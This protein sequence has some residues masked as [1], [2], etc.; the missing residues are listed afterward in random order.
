MQFQSSNSGNYQNHHQQAI[1][2]SPLR[3]H[4]SYGSNSSS[5]GVGG[6]MHHH[7]H[8]PS[9]LQSPY[10]ARSTPSPSTIAS[11][12]SP[13]F[14]VRDLDQGLDEATGAG[15]SNR[16]NHYNQHHHAS[17][18]SAS[19]L[20]R[21][22][23]HGT[24]AGRESPSKASASSSSRMQNLSNQSYY[25]GGSSSSMNGSSSNDSSSSSS[26]TMTPHSSA[27]GSALT[28]TSAS[29]SSAPTA[30]TST[31]SSTATA[32]PTSTAATQARSRNP[33]IDLIETEKGYVDDLGLVIKK[34]AAAWSRSN[35]P[36]PALDKMFRA[37]ESVYRID[38]QFLAK[39][40]E[41]GPNPSSPKALGD[42]L[43]RWIDDLEPAYTKYVNAYQGDFDNY[44]PV[45]SNPNLQ[46]ILESL[47]T[48]STP[49]LFRP[50]DDDNQYDQ[51]QQQ[52]QQPSHPTLDALFTLPLE[53]L[54]YFKKLYG[55]L[56][57]ST[58]PGKSDHN[59]L[60]GANEKL[61][62]LVEMSRQ[63]GERRVTDGLSDE[64]RSM[65]GT[66]VTSA[67]SEQASGTIKGRNSDEQQRQQQQ[68][69][70]RQAPPPESQSQSQTPA[71]SPAK[72]AIQQQLP[73]SSASKPQLPHV[74]SA[75]SSLSSKGSIIPPLRTTDLSRPPSDGNAS[76][77]SASSVERSSGQTTASS[78]STALTDNSQMSGG[79][80]STA[81]I[82]ADLE[83]RLDTSRT[84][85]IFT[86]KPKKCKLQMNPPNLP[87]QR[88]IRLVG[89]VQVS[90]VPASSP[91]Q[92]EVFTPSAV[93]Y[94]LTDLFLLCER[95]PSPSTEPNRT[96]PQADFW[97][98]YPPLA[99]KHL[100]AHR[101]Q[102][103]NAADTAFEVVIMRKERMTVYAESREK[104]DEWLEAFQEAINFGG[105]AGALRVN[106]D[107]NR[108]ISPFTAASMSA[109]GRSTP[110]SQNGPSPNGGDYSSLPPL[111]LSASTSNFPSNSPSPYSSRAPT[112]QETQALT[113]Q[114]R[115][116]PPLQT[117]GLQPQRIQSPENMSAPPPRTHG[118]QP[119]YQGGSLPSGQG[120][121]P[122]P[123]RSQ[124]SLPFP[125]PQQQ[126][127]HGPMSSQSPPMRA[128]P[129]PMQQS[130]SQPSLS[131]PMQGMQEGPSPGGY[132]NHPQHDSYPL[133]NQ[134][135][136]QYNENL[137]PGQAPFG[138][139]P[140]PPH[141][142]GLHKAP[143]MRSVGSLSSRSSGPG[144][145]HTPSPIPPLP[146]K[147]QYPQHDWQAAQAAN[148]RMQYGMQQGMGEYGMQPDM[149]QGGLLSP[150][151]S[152]AGMNSSMSSNGMIHR[153]KSAE[154]LRADQY[155]MPSAVL[156]DSLR[157]QSMPT[158]SGVRSLPNSRMNSGY[159]NDTELDISPPTSPQ[160]EGPVTNQLAAQMKCKVF[161]QSAKNQW[162]SLGTA[163]L[164]LYLQSPGNRKQLV[165]EDKTVLISTIVLEDGVERVGKT[166]VAIELSDNGQRTGLIYMLQLKT[167]ASATG[168][169][170]QLLLG[171]TRASAMVLK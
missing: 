148:Q 99:T 2:A 141:S 126:I 52:Q 171:S 51:Q 97:L 151:R 20:N 105:G 33:L 7:H 122:P 44:P 130:F 31:S 139:Q 13:S 38:K 127:G 21:F 104:R 27:P 82:L 111:P 78:A 23:A 124:A 118:Q 8:Q 101:S 143:S 147:E 28:P 62:W 19:S 80:Q 131:R 144:S 150:S 137:P 34:V 43:M 119:M 152:Q 115:A 83:K 123:P 146:M 25:A 77:V 68:S 140:P 70:Q 125:P 129:S 39:L 26:H 18:S 167:E 161:V 11:G 15:I 40:N 89:D 91:S 65:N 156:K 37:V 159:V 3:M 22:N 56:L 55:K 133:P 162:K 169:F 106:T 54:Q 41:I 58:Q 93:I 73:P 86:M 103:P 120:P 90:F 94:L 12:G 145:S 108:S 132:R 72:A 112:P 165:V 166:G 35:F 57:K 24:A 160:L 1:A 74:S 98:M 75:H 53:R 100:R 45:Q 42:L 164:K 71:P 154:G 69:Q 9:H 63:S 29:M 50:H 47:P 153:S 158:Q 157:G 61:D 5:G 16:S 168:L 170:Q 79:A 138:M 6:S 85:D 87:Y 107:I 49:S 64:S 95:I 155:R 96:N 121:L 149:R 142:E 32:T 92:T 114:Q 110:N 102:D 128:L 4:H 163:K 76:N 66:P 116:L 134:Q 60:V 30:S 46:A 67:G 48:L 36:P 14:H 109:G 84:L 135:Y 113:A 17:T 136:G 117:Q 10:Q 59:L 81:S 88:S